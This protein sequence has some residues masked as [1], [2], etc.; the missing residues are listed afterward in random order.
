MSAK[1]IMAI[2]IKLMAIFLMVGVVLGSVQS[3]V[4]FH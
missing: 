3:F 1:G 2:A 4:S